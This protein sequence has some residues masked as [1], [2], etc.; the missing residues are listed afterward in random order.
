MSLID[1]KNL[2][3]KKLNQDVIIKSVE[4]LKKDYESLIKQL[5][6]ST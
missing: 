6:N 3:T 1:D 2:E 5:G 4:T